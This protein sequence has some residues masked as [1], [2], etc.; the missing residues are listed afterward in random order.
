MHPWVRSPELRTTAVPPGAPTAPL[1]TRRPESWLRRPGTRRRARPS[2]TCWVR[3]GVPTIPPRTRAPLSATARAAGAWPGGRWRSLSLR[4]ARRSALARSAGDGGGRTDRDA[5]VC[6]A[7]RMQ[8]LGRIDTVDL[9]PGEA[10]G[11]AGTAGVADAEQW[12]APTV[13]AAWSVK[14]LAAHISATISASSRVGATLTRL[15]IDA[16]SYE[17][18]VPAINDQNE[19]WVAA[20]RRASPRHSSNCCASPASACTRTSVAGSRRHRRAGRLGRTR[21]RS[22]SGWTSPASTPS[23]GRT[24]SRSATPSVRRLSTRRFFAP[25]STATRGAPARL[26]RHGRARWHARPA[27]DHRRGRRR[28]VARARRAALGAFAA[29]ETRAGRDH[30]AAAGHRVARSSRRA[31]RRGSAAPAA[32]Y[33]DEAL[34]EQVLHTVAVLA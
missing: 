4:R 28:L 2:T 19:P 24:S 29:V 8:P 33:G 13:C 27:R 26:P 1:P 7:R 32:L 16:P 9:F 10:R 17:A 12:A 31:S 21:T 6:Y 23:A 5:R 30:D 34:G 11:A 14:D 25:S 3:R 15:H 22:P 18:L 20:M